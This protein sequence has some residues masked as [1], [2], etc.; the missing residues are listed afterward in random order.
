MS[1]V[2]DISLGDW[3][4]A[5]ILAR[6]GLHGIIKEMPMV[7]SYRETSVLRAAKLGHVHMDRHLINSGSI[8]VNPFGP[9][10]AFNVLLLG[11][12]ERCAPECANNYRSSLAEYHNTYGDLS[13]D[14]IVVANERVTAILEWQTAR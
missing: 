8:M 2:S 1:L 6:H 7:R 12:L 9:L 14:N 11:G 3:Y 5:N 13:G 10:N 4:W